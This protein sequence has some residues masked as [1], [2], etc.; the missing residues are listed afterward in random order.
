MW[1]NGAKVLWAP[2]RGSVTTARPTVTLLPGANQIVVL[3]TD[4]QGL[5]ARRSFGIR[6]EVMQ[7]AV[8]DTTDA[9]PASAEE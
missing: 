7:S 9:D 3:A 6:G 2:G 5:A 8:V 1:V 4:D